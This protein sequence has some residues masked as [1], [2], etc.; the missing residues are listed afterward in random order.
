VTVRS[1]TI[2]GSTN[3]FS[4]NLGSGS[5]TMDSGGA[6]DVMIQQNTGSAKSTIAANMTLNNDLDIINRAPGAA[7]FNVSSAFSGNHN[8]LINPGVPTGGTPNMGGNSPALTG[9]FTIC[10]GQWLFN[11]GDGAFGCLSNGTRSIIIS[12]NAYLRN[13]GSLSSFTTNRQIVVGIGGGGWSVHGKNMTLSYPAQLAGTNTFTLLTDANGYTVNVFTVSSTNDG[14]AGTMLLA[15]NVT[16]KLGANGSINNSPL[17]N[18][19]TVTSWFDVTNKL[20]GYAI[21]AGQVLAGIGVITGGVNVANATAK[22]HPGAYSLPGPTNTPG[23]LNISGGLSFANNG[24]YA[25]DLNQLKDSAYAPGTTTYA[26]INVTNGTVNLS[27]GTLA[28]NFTGIVSTNTPSS[29]NAFWK[30]G[31]TWT[32]LTAPTPPIG[33]LAVSNGAYPNWVFKTQVSGNTLQLV[34]TQLS[35]GMAVMVR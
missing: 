4:V 5:L 6:G 21:P 30:S 19:S 26:Q 10:Y 7:Y 23:I 18:L 28:I 8:V 29:T 25:W 27:G 33:V 24:V 32:I 2:G 1:I 16:L 15:D 3:A 20:S 13:N 12:N 35:R 34:Y 14:F 11:G 22:I 9:N 17:I 31:H